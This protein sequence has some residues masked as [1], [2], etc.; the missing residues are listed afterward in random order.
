MN[1]GSTTSPYG[2]RGKGGTPGT[3]DDGGPTN[4]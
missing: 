3:I 1:Y 2:P 4:V